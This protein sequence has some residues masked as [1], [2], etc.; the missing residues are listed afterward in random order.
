MFSCWNGA[1]VIDARAFF[2]AGS[3][4]SSD[5]D[6]DN[7]DGVDGP[8]EG[9]DRT[10]KGSQRLFDPVPSEYTTPS[11]AIRFRTGRN[12]VSPTT[13]KASECFL[14]CVDLWRRGMGKIL[15][16][17]RARYV[18]DFLPSVSC[19]ISVL[20][21]VAYDLWQYERVR[22]DGRRNDAHPIGIEASTIPS[23]KTTRVPFFSSTS[24][25]TGRS[26]SR[27]GKD[28]DAKMGEDVIKR[29]PWRSAPPTM[30]VY[31]DYAWWHEK[32]V[33]RSLLAL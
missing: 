23:R 13:E 11:S 27:T 28:S 30:V 20:F 5:S 26:S 8:H 17:P 10:W 6:N 14:L 18:V 3:S 29:V 21:S 31:H 32:E 15:L 24:G 19:P 7:E 1:V 4:D 9:H 16:V 12:D 25:S 2:L 22:Q 33:S